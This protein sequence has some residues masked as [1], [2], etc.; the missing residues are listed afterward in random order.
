MRAT[1][2]SKI[3]VVLAAAGSAVGLGNIWRF[4]T[5]VG[6]NGGAA[7]IIV[8]IACVA[9]FGLPLMLSEFLIGRH[10]HA[11]TADAYKQLA[12]GTQW[13][14]VGQAGVFVAWIILCYYIVVAGW[15]L[16]YMV[17]ACIDQLDTSSFGEFVADP[18]TPLLCMVAFMLMTHVI[19]V[20]G[21]QKGIERSSKLMMPMLLGIIL[22]L[23]V[24]SFSMPGTKEATRFLFKPDFSAID[25]EVVLSALGQAFYSLSLAMGCL[26]TYASYFNKDVNLLKTAGSV[27]VIDTLVAV[28]SG[29]IIFPAVFSVPGVEPD[30]GAGLVF[31]TLPHVFEIAFH[32]VPWL[33]YIFA[34][35]FY[36]LLLLSALTSAIGLLEVPVLFM[37]E[38]YNIERKTATRIVTASCIALG[39][40]CSL[41]FGV[42]GDFTIL[43]RNIFDTFDAVPSMF[44]MPLTGMLT[45]IFVG[46]WLDRRL[47][48]SE[49]TNDGRLRFPFMRAYIIIVRYVA[50]LIIAA[51]FIHQLINI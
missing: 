50:P 41:S 17:M 9:F 39:T 27:C 45:C 5:E 8:Y 32:S 31:V 15:T 7:F 6:Q 40:L 34:V 46:W 36:L 10:S 19:V 28:T 4:P 49:L 22:I 14:R 26:C 11:N 33:G 12:P 3:G 42:L 47:V 20:A 51:I 18:L 38:H 13:K 21:V 48:E 2:A 1:F 29:F 44:I 25:T 37:H 23:V 43:G 35:M 16:Y 30:A 24:C